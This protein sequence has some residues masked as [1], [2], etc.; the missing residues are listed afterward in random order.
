MC[1]LYTHKYCEKN[2]QQK[3]ATSQLNVVKRFTSRDHDG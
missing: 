2:E 3:H 1:I